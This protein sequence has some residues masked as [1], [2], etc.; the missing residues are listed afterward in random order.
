M[1]IYHSSTSGVAGDP[2][3]PSYGHG[4]PATNR[5]EPGIYAKSIDWTSATS[6]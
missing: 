3:Q 2:E 1:P 4:V 6:P 5:L